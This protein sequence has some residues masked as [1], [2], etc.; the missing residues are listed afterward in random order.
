[1]NILQVQ[2]HSDNSALKI[3]LEGT[4]TFGSP[5]GNNIS[6]QAVIAHGYGSDNLLWQIAVTRSDTGRTYLAP[7][8]SADGRM[9][10]YGILD[11]TNLTIRGEL[12]SAG[13]PYPAVTWTYRYRLLIP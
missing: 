5:A 11:A 12:Y 7:I 4:G 3:L 6:G 10:A 1:M 9:G 2:T 13:D 8:F